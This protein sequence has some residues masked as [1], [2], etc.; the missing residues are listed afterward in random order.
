MSL[1]LT[2]LADVCR[3][4]GLEVLEQ[5]GW[6]FRARSSGGYEA[7]RPTHVI[8]HH[9]ASGPGSDGW[10]DCDYMSYGSDIAPIANLYLSRSGAVYVLAAGCTNTNGSGVDPCGDVPDDAMNTYAI[11]IEAAND[12]VGEPW[13]LEQQD[14]YV[15]LV[16]QLCGRYGIDPSAVHSHAEW[17]PSRKIDPAGPSRWAPEGGT[18]PMDAFRAELGGPVPQPPPNPGEDDMA[19]LGYF[20][21]DRPDGEWQI[22]L[23]GSDAEGMSWTCPISDLPDGGKWDVV[24]PI[25]GD[26]P[27]RPFGALVALMDRQNRPTPF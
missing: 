6:Q 13:P 16:E 17:A 10:D 24:Q 18:W 8:V 14:A 12:G 26:P 4:A 9:T 5:E 2:D 15:T 25:V 21:D 3:A 11:G 22:W 23:V 19:A 7:G 1:Y 20:R 27:I